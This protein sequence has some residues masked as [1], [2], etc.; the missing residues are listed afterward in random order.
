M[1]AILIIFLFPLSLALDPSDI[2]PSCLKPSQ[3]WQQGSISDIAVNV[4]N[5]EACQDICLS[6]SACSGITWFSEDATPYPLT[7][8]IFSNISGP[9]LACENCVSGPPKCLC[10]EAGEC[11]I[12]DGNI[13]DVIV[14]VGSVDVC[15][16]LCKS[17]FNCNFYTFLGEDNHLRKVKP[18]VVP[19]KN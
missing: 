4:P 15:E 17:S 2:F 14:G 8:Y 12:K 1:R 19:M 18:T 16:N 11:E 13:I 6:S 10:L 7:C 5:P 3:T 9:S